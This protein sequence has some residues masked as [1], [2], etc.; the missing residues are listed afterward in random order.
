MNELAERVWLLAS[1]PEN[2]DQVLLYADGFAWMSCS[3]C[4]EKG[5]V[6]VLLRFHRVGRTWTPGLPDP[7]TEVFHL[8][9]PC[10]LHD[11]MRELFTAY[12][13]TGVIPGYATFH[14]LHL[15][16]KPKE[17]HRTFKCKSAQRRVQSDPPKRGK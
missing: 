10:F 14:S 7:L 6:S 16:L 15:V 5:S 11:D 17:L 9:K 1:D 4:N 13:D 2:W 12:R 3:G 8:C